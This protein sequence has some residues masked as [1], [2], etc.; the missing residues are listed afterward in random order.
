MV[1]DA[2]SGSEGEEEGTPD[3][4]TDTTSAQEQLQT[5]AALSGCFG[6]TITEGLNRP[7]FTARVR[8]GN[9]THHMG[10][11]PSL[12]EA[13]AAV[14]KT[15]P[16]R[17]FARQ[18]RVTELAA[19]KKSLDQAADSGPDT[20]VVRKTG[21]SV[22]W[23]P[24]E[25]AK[26]HSVMKKLLG[27]ERYGASSA[28]VKGGVWKAVAKA[29][30]YT[31]DVDR[32]ARRCLR[33]WFLTDPSNQ[34]VAAAV[35]RR[36]NARVRKRKQRL[37]RRAPSLPEHAPVEDNDNDSDDDDSDEDADE[38]AD[39][40]GDEECDPLFPDLED[41]PLQD[42]ADLCF[43]DAVVPEAAE[44]EEEEEEEEKG[45][46]VFDDLTTDETLSPECDDADDDDAIP[47][48]LNIKTRDRR[49]A[50]VKNAV[51]T[52]TFSSTNLGRVY[53]F[54][55]TKQW[56]RLLDPD[57][58]VLAP[59]PVGTPQPVQYPTTTAASAAF[60]AAIAAAK[61]ARKQ[62]ARPVPPPPPP[63]A[64][65][66]LQSPPVDEPIATPET[67]T[68]PPLD[69]TV[70]PALVQETL[71]SYLRICKGLASVDPKTLE[72]APSARL[73]MREFEDVAMRMVAAATGNSD[74]LLHSSSPFPLPT[75]A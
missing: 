61:R 45:A 16:G 7:T 67:T 69:A 55:K 68:T 51:L 37:P 54:E 1:T 30:G 46:R 43:D 60:V 20:G 34:A 65:A 19:T 57:T 6:V 24:E 29:M 13:A 73:L 53:K 39:F 2:S 70:A 49:P 11:Y 59:S 26:L 47:V 15:A 66:Q 5:V 22:H 4:V 9:A 50:P 72:A 32:G 42:F 3:P 44:E 27:K 21:R 36:A 12:E 56:H 28:R 62:Q 38:L 52:Y 35:R 58:R 18:K 14:L 10:S 8:K 23:T 63:E 71:D 17:R 75:I 31:D 40:F 74:A 48:V 25:D 33:H 64:R 41:V